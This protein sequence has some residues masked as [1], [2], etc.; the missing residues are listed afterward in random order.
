MVQRTSVHDRRAGFVVL[1]ARRGQPDGQLPKLKRKASVATGG[2]HTSC[3]EIH[4]CWNVDRLARIDPPIQT[5]YFRSGGATI[6]TFIDEG[7][8]AVISLP[9]RSAVESRKGRRRGGRVSQGRTSGKNSQR[10]TGLTDPR[11]HG[12][13]SGH[14]DVAVQVLSDVCDERQA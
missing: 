9:I 2:G 5:E 4:I 13:P 7:A 12:R 10:R 3:F 6:L 14:D 8:S 11:V 1:D